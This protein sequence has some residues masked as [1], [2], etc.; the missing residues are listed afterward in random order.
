[1]DEV[2]KR[3]CSYRMEVT[4]V[5]QS[6]HQSPTLGVQHLFQ[7]LLFNH[8]D[9]VQTFFDLQIG[10]DERTSQ[11]VSHQQTTNKFL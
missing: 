9:R 2:S 1:M 3:R 10:D 4:L 6:I 11:E 5:E 7:P 8:N